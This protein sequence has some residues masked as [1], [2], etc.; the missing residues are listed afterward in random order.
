MEVITS[1]LYANNL[2]CIR[3]YVQNAI[4]GSAKKIWIDALNDGASVSILDNGVGMTFEELEGALRVGI[5]FKGK[6]N[7]G[8]RGIGI[9]S[10]AA[11]CKNI[12]VVTKKKDG[13]KLHV[14]ISCEP[15]VRIDRNRSI[16]DALTEAVPG[17]I[18]ELPQT[19]EDDSRAYTKITLSG[20]YPPLFNMFSADS[21]SRYLE[22]TMPLE[23]N[24]DFILA[25]KIKSR[26]SAY[27]II[28][29]SSKIFV[30]GDEIKRDPQSSN[31]IFDDLIFKEFRPMMTNGKLKVED[32]SAPALA[33]GWFVSTN[34]NN[35]LKINQFGIHYRKHGVRVGDK[36]LVTRMAK[37]F[38]E[39]QY[40]EIHI[41]DP[42][43]IEDAGRDG[44]E[45]SGIKT[46]HLMDSVGEFINKGLNPLAYLTSGLLQKN[47]IDKIEIL[48]EEGH[49]DSAKEKARSIRK[50]WKD[51]KN[52]PG[53]YENDIRPV[54]DEVIAEKKRQ[55]DLLDGLV[56]KSSEKAL[57]VA[58][59]P[60]PDKFF[61]TLK[62]AGLDNTDN[63]QN[64]I[65]RVAEELKHLSKG[66][67]YSRYPL[68]SACLLRTAYSLCIEG[69]LES[70]GLWDDAS[71]R[72]NIRGAESRL[73][74]A[75]LDNNGPFRGKINSNHR[76][77]YRQLLQVDMLSALSSV[78]HIPGTCAISSERL[79]GIAT[80]YR[81]CCF[82]QE[83]IKYLA[84]NNNGKGSP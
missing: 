52:L 1:G 63:V 12:D 41:L 21:I 34:S 76:D 79:E 67:A 37:S 8:W 24:D 22:G 49:D 83:T 40:G 71:F 27:D 4:D 69:M 16:I 29:S 31:G 42:E 9:W 47:N 68:A 80:D 28:I 17:E 11:I 66:R 20:I 59:D 25:E 57:S 74:S 54:L 23:F 55:E 65:I 58:M 44:L 30:N 3:E 43:I 51:I 38:K 84:K 15:L 13:S 50:K 78:V 36:T 48:L 70:A 53:D 81:G 6:N 75:I 18:E 45:V 32:V 62:W 73:K 39:W 14:S 77:A 19:P 5:S 82:I 64:G 7:I 2:N 26:L 46:M 10:G 60:R 35:K 72:K 33:V 56:V 61:G